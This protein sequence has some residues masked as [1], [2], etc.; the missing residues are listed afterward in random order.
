MEFIIQNYLKAIF[1]IAFVLILF[2]RQSVLAESGKRDSFT[3][4]DKLEHFAI[5]AAMTASTAFV[6]HNHFQTRRDDSIVI[7]FTASL[8][9]GGIKELIDKRT[10]GEQSSWKDLMADIIGC[11]AGAILIRSAIK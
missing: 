11:A 1:I 4:K 3:G 6:L 10:P 7:G 2:G 5:S 8:S 9:L